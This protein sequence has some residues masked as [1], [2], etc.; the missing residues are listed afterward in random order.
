MSK[1][2]DTPISDL[3]TGSDADRY[4]PVGNTVI[5]YLN[6]GGAIVAVFAANYPHGT[7]SGSVSPSPDANRAARCHGCGETRA[8]IERGD[9]INAVRAWA[10]KHSAEC[11]ALPQPDESAPDFRELASQYANRAAKLIEGSGTQAE[12][13]DR[14]GNAMA[15]V[16]IA[17]IY[18]RLAGE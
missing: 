17:D 7:A 11:R 3:V 6:Q 8:T 16:G 5:R 14:T 4:V 10:V 18:A 2:T 13:S 12:L 9:L 1:G 15:Y